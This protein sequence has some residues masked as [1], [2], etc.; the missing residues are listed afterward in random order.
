M[1]GLPIDGLPIQSTRPM[2][3]RR[4]IRTALFASLALALW[5]FALPARASSAPFCDDRGASASAMP[6]ALDAPDEVLARARSCPT[7]GDELSLFVT[8]ARTQP[9]S[10]PGLEGRDGVLPVRGVILPGVPGAPLDRSPP[11]RLASGGT[12]SRIERPPR[13]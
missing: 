2:A 1:N 9:A 11:A 8:I 3:P 7:G 4:V 10:A 5:A 12:T 13:T 6:P